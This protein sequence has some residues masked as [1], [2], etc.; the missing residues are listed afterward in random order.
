MDDNIRQM[1]TV[2]K[3]RDVSGVELPMNNHQSLKCEVDTRDDNF[4]SCISLA[5]ELLSTNHY[6]STEGSIQVCVPGQV[7]F[8]SAATW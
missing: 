3:P 6:A 2:E 4:T 5:K 8:R 7:N 1:N